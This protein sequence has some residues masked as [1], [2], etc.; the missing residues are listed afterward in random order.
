MNVLRYSTISGMRTVND[1]K[2]YTFADDSTEPIS[3]LLRFRLPWL[4]LGLFG[5]FGAALLLGR[6]E[7]VLSKNVELAFFLPFIVYLSDAVGTQ[8][9]EIYIRNV[10]KASEA[11]KKFYTYLAKEAILGV[12][13]GSLFGLMTLL[14][15]YLWLRDLPVNITIGLSMGISVAMAPIVALIIARIF[16]IEHQDPAA[17]AGP[18]KTILQDVVSIIIYFSIA[19]II[20]FN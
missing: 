15:S 7:A 20:L 10:K 3:V 18:F 16:Q 1:L 17:G 6:Y 9:E 19:S 8:T 5:G 4:T 2:K 11:V 14:L 13:F 12:M